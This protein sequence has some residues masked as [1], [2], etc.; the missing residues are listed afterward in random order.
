[1]ADEAVQAMLVSMMSVTTAQRYSELAKSQNEPEL[2]EHLPS[3]GSVGW[4][5]SKSAKKVLAYIPG[6]GLVTYASGAQIQMAYDA[7]KTALAAAGNVALAILSY[8]ICAVAEYPSQLCQT[9]SFVESLMKDHDPE[10]IDLFGE[11]AGGMLI[12]SMLLHV[13]HNHPKVPSLT[14]PVGR[15]FHRALL[16]SPGGPVKTSAS[17]MTGNDGKDGLTTATLSALW[18]MIEANHDPEVDLVNPWLTPTLKMFET[19]YENWPIGEISIIIG[20]DEILRDDIIQ[21]ANV[22]KGKHSAEVDV[23]V[24]PKSG[25]CAI[26]GEIMRQAPLSEYSLAVYEWAK[27]I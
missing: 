26:V 6:G 4:F 12:I 20:D 17:S 23:H 22:I 16:I 9:V 3:G 7:Y 14:M 8:D 15:K 24:Y 21:V 1:M 27:K 25:H 19:W 13:S 10:D 2:I 11:S 5:G 18:A